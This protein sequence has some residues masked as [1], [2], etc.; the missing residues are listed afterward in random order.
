MCPKLSQM[1][2]NQHRRE[3]GK[4]KCKINKCD[5][6]KLP[7]KK[8][9]RKRWKEGKKGRRKKKYTHKN[10]KKFKR[11]FTIVMVKQRVFTVS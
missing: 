5:E 4:L 8:E 11:C 7:W 2:S 1:S 6:R 10:K 9:R 3:A